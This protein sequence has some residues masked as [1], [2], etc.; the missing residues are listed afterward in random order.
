MAISTRHLQFIKLVAKGISQQD[1]YLQT[2]SNKSITFATARAEGSKLAKKYKDEID[3]EIEKKNDIITKAG[4]S[5]DVQKA[6][7]E[8]VSEAEA[9]AKAFRILTENDLV[10]DFHVYFGE[11]K[12]FQRKPTQA[13]IIKAY[14]AYCLRF[15][16]NATAK[17][18]LS[19]D[20]PLTVT[21]EEIKKIANALDNIV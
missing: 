10:D 8:I 21:N 2:S 15:G 14:A 11:V 1:A 19:F 13:E 18:S 9:D 20:N 17:T 12:T 5:K 6:V 16:K 7:N 4:E 3:A